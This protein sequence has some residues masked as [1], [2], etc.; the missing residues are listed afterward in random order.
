V[1]SG[2]KDETEPA[3]HP[4]KAK[5]INKLILDELCPHENDG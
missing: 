5:S 4:V 1:T 2:R 3:W